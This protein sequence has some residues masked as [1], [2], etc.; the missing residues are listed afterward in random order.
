MIP[1]SISK[2]RIEQISTFFS[3]ITTTTNRNDYLIWKSQPKK[4]YVYL[5][6]DTCMYTVY[7]PYG[8]FYF[9][10]YFLTQ[11]HIQTK[12]YFFRLTKIYTYHTMCAYF[13]T[14]FHKKKCIIII[15]FRCL[16]VDVCA[17]VCCFFYR[18]FFIT[19]KVNIQLILV[20]YFDF[21]TSW[22]NSLCQ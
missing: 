20:F 4:M 10:C 15:H 19:S 17:L 14:Y 13:F 7:F 1:K 6:V 21:S 12:R 3:N 22:I 16:F 2:M 5:S 18:F 11:P 9:K 8:Y